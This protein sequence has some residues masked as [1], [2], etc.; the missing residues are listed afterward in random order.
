MQAEVGQYEPWLALDG[1]P[2]M[3]LNSLTPICQGA[4]HMLRPGG[5]LALETT[6]KWCR[7]VIK[8]SCAVSCHVLL[9][10]NCSVH[11]LPL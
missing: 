2:G 8:L 5:F 1:G 6:G 9:V 10:S 3:G 4:A 11:H 7:R